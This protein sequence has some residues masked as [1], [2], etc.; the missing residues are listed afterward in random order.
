MCIERFEKHSVK[1]TEKAL[2]AA[3]HAWIKLIKIYRA[4]P[5]SV[6]I[7]RI[8]SARSRNLEFAMTHKHTE[9]Q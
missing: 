8:D 9:R 3:T 2:D 5:K 7:D 6:D 1:Y 4:S